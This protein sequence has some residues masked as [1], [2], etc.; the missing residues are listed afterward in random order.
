[1]SAYDWFLPLLL[2]LTDKLPL[3]LQ[4][5]IDK[6]TV[7]P[8]KILYGAASGQHQCER[9]APANFSLIDPQ[10]KPDTTHQPLSTWHNHPDADKGVAKTVRFVVKDEKLYEL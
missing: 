9:G 4:E 10:A 5:L 1:M 7:A 3:S 8:T 2:Q 6:V